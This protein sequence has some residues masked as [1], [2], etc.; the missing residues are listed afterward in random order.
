MVKNTYTIH[1][2]AGDEVLAY[3]I[4]C[5]REGLK[6][7]I[8]RAEEKNPSFVLDYVELVT[9][10]RTRINMDDEYDDPCPDCGKQLKMSN[11]GGV[12]CSCGYWFCY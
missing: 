10:Q 12:Y 9:E 2:N 5:T 4:H 11:S 8:K 7:Y 6:N 1:W 3:N